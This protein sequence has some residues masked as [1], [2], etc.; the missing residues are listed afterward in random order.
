M[1]IFEAALEANTSYRPVAGDDLVNAF[2]I[3]ITAYLISVVIWLK[4]SGYYLKF[5]NE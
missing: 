5:I 3:G 2:E 4:L 1:T